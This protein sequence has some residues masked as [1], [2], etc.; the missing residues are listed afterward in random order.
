MKH[1]ITR[2]TLLSAASLGVAALPSINVRAQAFPSRPIRLIVPAA[3]GG[4]T[5]AIAR[6]L[7]DGMSTVMK[8]TVVVE[9]KAGGG[10]TI[11]TDIVARSP[12]DGYM[13]VIIANA[14]A[15]NPAI[16]KKVPFDS[17]K[18]FTP[19]AIIA[20]SP[21]VLAAASASGVK[22]IKDLVELAKRNPQSVSFGSGEASARLLAER[23]CRTVGVP[24]THVNY[25]G[26][27]PMMADIAGGHLNYGLVSVAAALPFRDKVNFVAVTTGDR[28]SA[29][30]EVP[31]LTEQ[32]LANINSGVWYGI[33]GPANLPAAVAQ[34]IHSAIRTAMQTNDMKKKLV[35]LAM[36]PWLVDPD[37]FEKLLRMEIDMNLQ[38]A[39]QAGIVPE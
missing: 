2:R 37:S 25:K 39:M 8:Q 28:S 21:Y 26:N 32:G 30:P 27:G 1:P 11:G 12:A 13:L 24:V 33:V 6:A 17:V 36:D 38:I 9:N 18:D 31:T 3:P 5:D 10:M 22:T 29:I 4:G 7:A 14:H 19:L 20:K 34:Q 23:I 16:M 35:T 15:V